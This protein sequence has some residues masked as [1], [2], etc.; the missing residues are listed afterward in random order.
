PSPC[1]FSSPAVSATGSEIVAHSMGTH[2]LRVFLGRVKRLLTDVRL[3]LKTEK[4]TKQR[5][6][7]GAT[8]STQAILQSKQVLNADRE[9]EL[10]ERV[11]QG[12]GRAALIIDGAGVTSNAQDADTR[13]A[14][15]FQ[16]RRS[17]TYRSR[18]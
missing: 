10:I 2:E 5:T 16:E 9:K 18:R 4:Y 11:R 8:P 3:L 12:V 1:P 15:R 6:S 7:S 17:R 13:V 14:G